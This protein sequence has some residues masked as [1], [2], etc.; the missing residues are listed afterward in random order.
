M[1]ENIALDISLTHYLFLPSNA[2][3]ARP[4]V[5]PARMGAAA[6]TALPFPPA[7]APP[8]FPPPPPL[9]VAE[10]AG[11]VDE[12]EIVQR[13]AAEMQQRD[14]VMHLDDIFPVKQ[15]IPQSVCCI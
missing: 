4:T 14:T 11:E 15:Q 5:N 8:P 13:R 9:P 10:P 1:C 12:M 6:A 7:P 3:K 2:V